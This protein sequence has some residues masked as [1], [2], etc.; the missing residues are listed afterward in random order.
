[1]HKKRRGLGGEREKY[2]EWAYK[3]HRRNLIC[4]LS[5]PCKSHNI[6]SSATI[7][8]SA[9]LI[10]EPFSRAGHSPLAGVAT[11]PQYCFQERRWVFNPLF[12]ISISISGIAAHDQVGRSFPAGNCKHLEKKICGLL[13]A[14]RYQTKKEGKIQVTLNDMYLPR[15]C[16]QIVDL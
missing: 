5:N 7:L 6:L 13:T 11:H 1:M 14:T 2:Q 9:F 8:C 12:F 3:K 10:Q 15:I 4:L 16:V